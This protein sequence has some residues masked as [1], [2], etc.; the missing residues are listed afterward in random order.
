MR[1]ALRGVLKEGNFSTLR[2]RE[3][4]DNIVL[5][6]KKLKKSENEIGYT[7][8]G[9]TYLFVIHVLSQTIRIKLF[10]TIGHAQSC[11]AKMFCPIAHLQSSPAK[12]ICSIVHAQRDC[13]FRESYLV[14]TLNGSRKWISLFVFWQRRVLGLSRVYRGCLDKLTA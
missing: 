14:Q 1:K 13:S 9:H 6:Q 2:L 7:R 12:R 10:Y 11:P 5:L 4:V 3:F 8:N